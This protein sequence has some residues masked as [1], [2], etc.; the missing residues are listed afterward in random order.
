MRQ[1]PRN[2]SPWVKAFVVMHVVAITM[3]ALPYPKRPYMLGTAK[4]SV[5][6]SNPAAFARSFS[7]TV[8]QGFLYLNWRYIK[9]SPLMYYPGCTGFWQYWDMFSPDPADTD[10]YL[11]AEVKFKDG[12]VVPFHYPR[13]YDLPIPEKYLKERYRKFFENV[14]Q[15]SQAYGRPPVAQR[16]ALE[17]FT[18]PANPPVEV[19]LIRHTYPIKP[20]G[21]EQLKDYSTSEV[22]TFAVDQAKLFKD[23]GL[24]H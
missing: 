8:T 23:K 1:E 19:K 22:G 21:Q 11:S 3:W 9:L 20:P 18:D 13:V 7:D 12:T 4:F 24:A 14:N 2:A 15:D 5:D 17:S 10:L 16:I 6:T